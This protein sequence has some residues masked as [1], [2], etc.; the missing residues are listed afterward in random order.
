MFCQNDKNG[1]NGQ[2][3]IWYEACRYVMVLIDAG[4]FKDATRN[5]FDITRY[6]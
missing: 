2:P 4:E 3:H 5:F 6:S 1:V